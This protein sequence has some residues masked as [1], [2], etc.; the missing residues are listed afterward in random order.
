MRAIK[1]G[2]NSVN[3]WNMVGRCEKEFGEPD[4]VR[5]TAAAP[6]AAIVMDF[7]K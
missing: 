7:V 6:A 3:V 2:E 4:R 1:F 5:Q